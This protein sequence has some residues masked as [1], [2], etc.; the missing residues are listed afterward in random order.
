MRE[1]GIDPASISGTGPG[2]RIVEADVLRVSAGSG[3]PRRAPSGVAGVGRPV[4]S[5]FPA[6]SAVA[7]LCFSFS[8][9]ATADVTSLVE[10]ERQIADEVQ[11]ACGAPL[12]FSDFLLRAMG[13][14]LADCPAANRVW[15][16]QIC[17]ESAAADIAL[18]VEGPEGR[19]AIVIQQAGRIPFLDLV[20]RR[21][22]LTAGT[23]KGT[24]PFFV[25]SHAEAG[26]N[27]AISL[28]DFSGHPVDECTAVLA[29]LCTIALAAGRVAPRPA[30]F[31]NR[32][33][34]RQTLVLSLT[35]DGRALSPE[36]AAALLGRIVEL[37]EHPFLLLCE[38][39][40]A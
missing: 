24:V 16:G 9:R 4:P 15:Q 2:G 26:E 11:Q 33:C 27:A 38:R 21:A 6:P 22:E 28:C 31:E 35:A 29:P 19:V 34:L 5:A 25:Q 8:L 7:G 37:V 3:D 20:R 17:A 40:R 10:I 12:R 32:L 30:A 18:E 1:R 39:L 14:A 36:T 13:M 23:K